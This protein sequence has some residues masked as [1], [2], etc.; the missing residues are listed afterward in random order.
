MW[1]ESHST[2]GLRKYLERL[3]RLVCGQI[4]TRQGEIPDAI[5]S[6]VVQYLR[7]RSLIYKHLFAM[8]LAVNINTAL[9]I[10]FRLQKLGHKGYQS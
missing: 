7:R 2:Q 4:L 6:A 1:R 5:F 8:T 9:S 10:R 3:W